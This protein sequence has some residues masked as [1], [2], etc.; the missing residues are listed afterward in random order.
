MKRLFDELTKKYSYD[1]ISPR[2]SWDKVDILIHMHSE[3]ESTYIGLQ[4]IRTQGIEAQVYLYISDPSMKNHPYI[5][6]F[7]ELGCCIKF[8]PENCP[9]VRFGPGKPP[10]PT[11]HKQ[12]RAKFL[13]AARSACHHTFVELLKWYIERDIGNW[14]RYALI[15]FGDHWILEAGK[16]KEFCESTITGAYDGFT[17]LTYCSPNPPFTK[18]G[19]LYSTSFF[20]LKGFYLNRLIE[21]RQRMLPHNCGWEIIFKDLYK[22]LRWLVPYSGNRE[23]GSVCPVSGHNG[24]SP[25]YWDQYNYKSWLGVGHFHLYPQKEHYL[26]L[27]EEKYKIQVVYDKDKLHDECNKVFWGIGQHHMGSLEEEIGGQVA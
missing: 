24:T 6:L 4:L 26:R 14:D 16:F 3:I 7:E 19:T 27:L 25:Q 9:I 20:M 12:E 17:F 8:H 5:P 21:H 11:V 10:L 13:D 15:T 1:S 2:D 18:G 22:D 23:N